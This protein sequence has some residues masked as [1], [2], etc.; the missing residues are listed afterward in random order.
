MR[1]A[2]SL[3]GE[4]NL[5][6]KAS[7]AMP[8]AT[9]QAVLKSATPY[10]KFLPMPEISEL[11][12]RTQQELDTMEDS[13]ISR[14][15]GRK[16]TKNTIADYSS[17]GNG[18]TWQQVVVPGQGG[19][20]AQTSNKEKLVLA[21]EEYRNPPPP[22][23]KRQQKNENQTGGFSP[24]EDSTTVGGTVEVAAKRR[25]NWLPYSDVPSWVKDLMHVATADP[26]KILNPETHRRRMQ[27]TYFLYIQ[28]CIYQ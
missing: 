4:G 27:V 5:L 6:P 14:R 13:M 21:K 25:S 8:L 20:Q 24:A 11:G 22:P 18:F 2:I 12:K 10:C 9:Q 7:T 28:I 26:S 1:H 3:S 17:K 23:S 16:R 15:S 19:F